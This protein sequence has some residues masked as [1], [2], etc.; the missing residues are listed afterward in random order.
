MAH[1]IVPIIS[2][3]LTQTGHWSDRAHGCYT[4][5]SSAPGNR[6]ALKPELLREPNHH[7]RKST[8]KKKTRGP[9]PSSCD[10]ILALRS[11][12]WLGP[13]VHRHGGICWGCVAGPSRTELCHCAAPRASCSATHRK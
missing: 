7:E 6:L 3:A 5:L 12:Y 2:A 10:L 13:A 8:K 9:A 4:E 11:V 1:R